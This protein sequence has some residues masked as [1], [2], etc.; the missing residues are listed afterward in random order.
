MSR[1]LVPQLRRLP[2][3]WFEYVLN[4]WATGSSKRLPVLAADTAFWTAFSLP[5]LTLTILAA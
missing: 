1:Y 2:T 3:A 4:L 5:W